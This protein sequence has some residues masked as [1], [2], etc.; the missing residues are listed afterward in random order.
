[1][2]NIVIHVTRVLIFLILIKNFYK[3]NKNIVLYYRAFES[4]FNLKLQKKGIYL[5]SFFLMGD[6]IV[7]M[8]LLHE[9]NLTL[10][11]IW[12][13]VLQMIFLL[14]M[15]MSYGKEFKTNCNCFSLS[16][17]QK[18]DFKTIGEN[19]VFIYLYIIIIVLLK[20]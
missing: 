2:S 5:A 18:V 9:K 11:C 13:I 4:F 1:M 17:P 16:L 8:G 12:G 19:V 6:L 3:K 7:L 15:L 10:T 14:R 20:Y